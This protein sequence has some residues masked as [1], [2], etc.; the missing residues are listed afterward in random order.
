MSWTRRMT[1]AGPFLLLLLS[2]CQLGGARTLVGRWE[3][4]GGNERFGTAYEFY[5]DGTGV[6]ILSNNPF[7]PISGDLTYTYDPKTGDLS[8]TIPGRSAPA[9]YHVSF[10]S[11]DEIT[12]DVGL[13]KPVPFVRKPFPELP[14]AM[15]ARIGQALLGKD[16]EFVDAKPLDAGWQK[17]YA[18]YKFLA[19]T[20]IEMLVGG[21]SE[22]WL[23]RLK[24]EGE[25]EPGLYVLTKG[26]GMWG[27]L[28]LIKND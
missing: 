24:L 26:P 4:D 22:N 19:L 9:V 18:D 23:V 8:L 16:F 21:E 5:E 27:V 20:N 13:K 2:A 12:M 25:D 17:D 15:R 14:A 3:R 11:S 7:H 10:D 1:L 28:Q 6:M